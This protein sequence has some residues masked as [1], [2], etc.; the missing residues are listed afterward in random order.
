MTWDGLGLRLVSSQGPKDTFLSLRI[1][2]DSGLHPQIQIKL[3]Y[4]QLQIANLNEGEN[5]NRF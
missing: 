1:Q 2:M 5:P 3:Q 4:L